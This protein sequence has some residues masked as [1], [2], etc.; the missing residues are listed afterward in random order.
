MLQSVLMRLCC[1]GGG[2]EGSAKT[3]DDARVQD[4]IPDVLMDKVALKSHMGLTSGAM[5]RA[6]SG[7]GDAVDQEEET[8]SPIHT[9]STASIT[10][11]RPTNNRDSLNSRRIVEEKG[12]EGEE[13][14]EDEESDDEKAVT[15]VRSLS[16]V[17]S[18]RKNVT[19]VVEMNGKKKNSNSF[20]CILF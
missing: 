4:E 12:K 2:I 17:I 16:H 15:K 1:G 19:V 9:K 18:P 8:C 7:A 20:T 14:E 11:F 10:E 6:P 13:E 3:S 5:K